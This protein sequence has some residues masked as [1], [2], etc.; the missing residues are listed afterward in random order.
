MSDPTTDDRSQAYFEAIRGSV[1]GACLDARDD[2]RCGLRGRTCAIETHLP[3]V[4]EAVLA[5][6]SDHLGDY[7]AAIEAQV[8]RTCPSQDHEGVCHLR[9][10][11][12]CALYAYLPLVLDAIDEVRS[13]GAERAA[14]A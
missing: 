3:A 7:L 4:V 1:C 2:G 12:D 14:C 5:I 9:D 6:E 11:G 10:H 8:C 13:G